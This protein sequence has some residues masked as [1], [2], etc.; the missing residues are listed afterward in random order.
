MLILIANSSQVIS[1]IV[2]LR[3]N[4]IG[5]IHSNIPLKRITSANQVS[6]NIVET[7]HNPIVQNQN[8]HVNSRSSHHTYCF[9][10]KNQLRSV[11]CIKLK[12]E[13]LQTECKANSILGVLFYNR[14]SSSRSAI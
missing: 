1:A 7:R 9:L 2:T 8:S 12:S 10:F 14:N 11:N 4:I 3:S 6:T 5:Y 13:H